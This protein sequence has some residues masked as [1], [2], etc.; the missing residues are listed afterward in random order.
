MV[1]QLI[2]LIIIPIILGIVTVSPFESIIEEE[3]PEEIQEPTDSDFTIFYIVL[4]L[5]WLFLLFRLLRKY[6]KSV[7]RN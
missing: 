2:I 3:T 5:V 7:I 6:M 1:Y 4:G